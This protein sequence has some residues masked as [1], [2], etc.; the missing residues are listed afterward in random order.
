MNIQEVKATIGKEM[1]FQLSTLMLSQQKDEA[2]A[3][4]PWLSHWDNTTRTRVVLHEEVATVIAA[5]PT[6]NKLALKKEVVKEH[7]NVAEYTRFVVIIPTSVVM[8]L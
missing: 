2:G 4:Q 6:L 7:E 5:E 3:V 1:G 8:T